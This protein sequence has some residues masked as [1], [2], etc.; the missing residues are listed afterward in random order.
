MKKKNKELNPESIDKEEKYVCCEEI[1]TK[2]QENEEDEE[3]KLCKIRYENIRIEK[4]FETIK[5]QKKTIVY[6]IQYTHKG[7]MQSVKKNF[8][9]FGELNNKIKQKY[10]ENKLPPFPKKKPQNTVLTFNDLI[11]RKKILCSFLQNV[12]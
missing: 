8:R 7:K 11:E 2:C 4:F 9:E 12:N 5:Y 10:N 1:I 3:T 6:E